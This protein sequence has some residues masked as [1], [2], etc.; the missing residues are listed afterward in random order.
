MGSFP[1]KNPT[2]EL[3]GLR[4]LSPNPE[5]WDRVDASVRQYVEVT[6]NIEVVNEQSVDLQIEMG[7]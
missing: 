4:A 6:A 5:S 3:I 7:L 2:D 1:S